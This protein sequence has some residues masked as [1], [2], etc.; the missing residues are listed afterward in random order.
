MEVIS[1][2]LEDKRFINWVFNPNEELEEWW[3]L[4]E[5][6][7]PKESK[8]IL[9]ARQTLLNL[10][11]TDKNLS[12]EEKVLLFSQILKKIEEK[13]S[14]RKK[15]SVYI[16]LLKYAAVAVLFFSIGSILFYKK[17]NFNPQ[18]ESHNIS[19]PTAENE[20][21]LIRPNGESILLE[22]KNSIV[23]YKMD[24]NIAV[25]DNLLEKTEDKAGT[26][27]LHQLVIPYGKTSEIVLADGTKVYLN[28]GSSLVYPEY[29]VDKRREVL[30]VGEAFFEVSEDKEHPFIVQ[31]SDIR[32]KV[33]GTHFNIS[34]YH[35]DGVIETV[36]TEGK[37]EL[38]QNNSSLFSEKKVLEPGQLASFN[39][40]TQ[41]TS[42]KKVNT[43]NYTL[44]KD[45]V[46][47]FESTDLSRVIKK[48]ERYYNLRF[49]YSDPLLGTIKIS[50][51][52]DLNETREEIISRVALAATI[53]INNVNETSY[54][55]RKK[56]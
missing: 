28:A 12:E 35:S 29:F 26:P 41:V 48:L 56:E 15:Y 24:G 44:W 19:V 4:F 49:L 14:S 43:S 55:V 47:K 36:L 3:K 32:V 20:A 1:K 51:K 22:E 54:E 18:F 8:N 38:E 34:A 37:V 13:E 9:K 45:G 52:L 31:T 50:G 53:E 2:Y 21:K 5:K 33:L 30:L 23:E 7:N 27:E 46:Y 25:N 42:V 6:N 17:D 40:S 10:R 16:G 11:T 39:K